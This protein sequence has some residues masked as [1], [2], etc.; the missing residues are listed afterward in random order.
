M[1]QG[2]AK[3]HAEKKIFLIFE[4][5]HGW[6]QKF[7]RRNNLKSLSFVGKQGCG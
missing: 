5:S 6:L 2:Q 3:K 7:K 1:I 4:A